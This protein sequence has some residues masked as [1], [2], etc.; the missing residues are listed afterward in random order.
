M[1]SWPFQLGYFGSGLF[2]TDLL[3]MMAELQH[4]HF[5]RARSYTPV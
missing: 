5:M 3:R 2:E 1:Q 4:K